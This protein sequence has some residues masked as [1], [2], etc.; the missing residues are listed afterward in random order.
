M[1]ALPLGSKLLCRAQAGMLF[2]TSPA[3][4]YLA[5]SKLTPIM[6]LPWGC[7]PISLFGQGRS[8]SINEAKTP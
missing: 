2:T 5:D 4:Y 1:P 6:E 8:H 3:A 7:L